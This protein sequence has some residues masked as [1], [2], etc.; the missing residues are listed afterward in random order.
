MRIPG[1]SFD[2]SKRIDAS[3]ILAAAAWLIFNSHTEAFHPYPWMAADGMLGNA[4]F[5]FISGFGIQ[6][7]LSGR[8]QGF[9][10]FSARRLV[11]IYVPLLIVGL[12]FWV[13][14][15]RDIKMDVFQAFTTYVYPTNYTYIK[16]IL[17]CYVGLWVLSRLSAR[18]WYASIGVALTLM[19]VVYLDEMQ[20]QLVSRNL[21]LGSLPELLWN[22][23][24]WILVVSGAVVARWEV[25][26]KFTAARVLVLL[27]L[28]VGYLGAK[29]LLLV[30]GWGTALFPILFVLVFALCVLGLATLGTPSLV[31]RTMGI[32]WLGPFL[33]MSAALTL[34]IYL[35]HEP[36]AHI[37]AIS[38]IA[39]PLNLAA[40]LALT[41]PIAVV[42]GVASAFIQR[43]SESK[44]APDMTL[45]SQDR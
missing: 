32:P 45:G 23:Y 34:E 21:S 12:I 43:R 17:P 36:L 29:F 27:V 9:S 24:F 22:S 7:S 6:S 31:R 19:V 26:P 35:V 42:V 30:E 33:G 28:L 5:Y 39:Y 10:E 25:K 4:L 41:L 38:A 2:P 18:W 8:A 11:R 37:A 40:L 15:H 13:T 14:L 16:V 20:R 44:R 1:Y 3:L